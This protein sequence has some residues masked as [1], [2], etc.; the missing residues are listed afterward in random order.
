VVRNNPLFEDPQARLIS[1][2]VNGIMV[3]NAYFPNGQSP[4]SE[5]FDYKLRWLKALQSWVKQN[6]LENPQLVLIGDF[7]IAPEDLD[8]YDPKGL[9]ETI[10]HT[11]VER[12]HFA[13]LIHMGLVDAFRLFCDTDK[14]YTWWDYRNLA[15][16][17]NKGLRI[18]HILVSLALKNRIKA[19]TIDR[20]M[21]K[22]K[23]PSDHVPV[24]VILELL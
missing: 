9:Y 17:R 14:H 20:I 8:S 7:N 21:R 23:R 6:L 24:M 2:Q 13:E 15:F 4:E 5:K 1:S 11:S 10:H 22:N 18:D 12:M 19:C 16:Q 3:M